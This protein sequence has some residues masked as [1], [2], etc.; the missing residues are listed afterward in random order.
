VG[1]GKLETASGKEGRERSRINAGVSQQ[2]L[3]NVKVLIKSDYII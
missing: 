1:D 3:L 2:L